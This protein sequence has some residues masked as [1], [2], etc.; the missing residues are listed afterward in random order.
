MRLDIWVRFMSI[1]SG[2]GGVAV[3]WAWALEGV[4]KGGWVEARSRYC[5]KCWVGVGWASIWWGD[6]AGLGGSQMMESVQEP[7][8][9]VVV[10]KSLGVGEGY[11]VGKLSVCHRGCEWSHIFQCDSAGVLSSNVACPRSVLGLVGP[12]PVCLFGRLM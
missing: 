2:Y 3:L 6:W 7:R 1:R 4:C 9:G 8:Y 12:V 11:S 5:Y 10:Q